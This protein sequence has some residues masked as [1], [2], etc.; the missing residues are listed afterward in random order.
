[1]LRDFRRRFWVCVVLT[2]P[3]L[4]LSPMIQAW[5][6][7]EGRVQLPADLWILFA[8]GTAVFIYGG[9]PF[10]KGLVDEL[11]NGQPGMMTLIGV[12]ISVAYGYS[13]LVVFGVPGRVFFWELA[14]LI[15]V[16]LL[17]HWIEMR[18]VMGASG[19][20]E[21]I[22]K[23]I[24]SDAHRLGADGQTEE[25]PVT[26]LESGDRVRV[27]PGE[28]IPV[29]GVIIDGKTSIDESMI[30]GE[31]EPVS[32][33]EGDEVVGGSV[34]GEGSLTV[35]VDKTG[36]ETYLARVVQMVREAQESKSR[37]QDLANRAAYWLTII[38]LSAGTITL[39]AWLLLGSEF[40]YALER[41]VTVMVITC[42]HALGLAVPLV[43][44]VSTAMAA[45][46]G[47]LIRNR[48]AFERS[49]ALDA[50][51][52]DKTGTLTEG[53]FGVTEVLPT[54]EPEGEDEVLRLAAALENRSEHPIA[55][56]ITEAAEERNLSLPEVEDF[57]NLAGQ[58]VK[59]EVEGH[60]VKVVKPG[61]LEERDIEFDRG[62][63]Q[64][65]AAEG[66]TVVC[67]VVDGQAA[68]LIALADVIRE[69]SREAVRSLKE[70]GI[71]MM[72][73]TGDSSAV[74]AAVAEELGLDEFF[75]EVM[76]DEKADRIKELEER[77]STVAMVGDGVNDAPALA[78]A[79]VGIAIGAGTDVAAETADIVLVN[80]DPRD[81]TRAVELARRTYRKT[82]Q[83][84]WWAAGYN[85]L[86]IPLAAGVLAWAGI[87]L[88]PAVGALVMSVSTVVVAVNA[89]LLSL[90]D[91]TSPA[92]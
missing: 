11:R 79:D 15:D 60:S 39:V 61:Y 75:A 53:R 7:I 33:G 76:P 55:R 23:L 74:A 84:L 6:G 48:T 68:G 62:R 2:V 22:V 1:M 65:L 90:S 92:S 56:G 34:N 38:A 77:G 44:A 12:A 20:L 66:K 32:R 26:E 72:M 29:D 80:S 4:A 30:T 52:F 17:G 5:L 54:G 63:V 91:H 46:R 43:I 28:R 21:E 16:M 36:E 37:Q 73:I 88:V 19:A 24:P 67:L 81:V 87:V 35:Q 41:A 71:K 25:V 49:R 57:E 83:N 59:A 51:V 47:L 50:V 18:S 86:A 31:S 9:W 69:E 58:G 82:V 10:L 14:T 40:V 8:V 27:K 42:P 70:M 89:R 64:E 78:E 3:I 45:R 13:A 85:I